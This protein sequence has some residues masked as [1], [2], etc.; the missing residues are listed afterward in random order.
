[1][2]GKKALHEG[3]IGNMVMMMLLQAI[4]IALLHF[5]S[6]IMYNFAT[7]YLMKTSNT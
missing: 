6:I 4:Y 1:M 2:A 5:F 7:E 3:I